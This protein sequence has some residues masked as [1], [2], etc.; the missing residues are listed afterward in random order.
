MRTLWL[1]IVG[2]MAVVLI[3]ALGAVGYAYNRAATAGLGVYV[4]TGGLRWAQ[5]LA[6]QLEDYYARVGSWDGVAA[7]L[8][9]YPTPGAGRG[10]G[11]MAGAGGGLPPGQR[12][13]VADA[14]GRVVADTFGELIGQTLAEDD[15]QQGAPL[16]VNGA[17]V[18]TLVVAA[19]MLNQGPEAEFLTTV[20]NGIVLGG[21]LAGVLA[22][23]LGSLLAFQVTSPL[24]ALTRA[25]RR[26]AGGDLAQRIPVRSRD[27]VG[28]LTQAFNEMAAAL[29]RNEQARRNMIADIAH[30]LRTPLTAIRGN[31]EGILDGVFPASG[32][33]V[34]P[35]YEQTLLLSRL[36]DDLRDLAL[37]D[38][39]QLRL[40]RRPLDVAELLQG[41][42]AA[43]QP[44]A[45]A[46]GIHLEVRV[47]EALP[48]VHA[49]P[50]RMR[51]VL[52]NLVGNALRH[53]PEGGAITLA[54]EAAEGAITVSVRDTG[55]GIDPADLPRIFD[56][57]YRGDPSRA[58][59]SGGHGL[60]LAIVKRWV[61]LHGGRV[62]AENLPSGGAQFSFTL[63]V[64]SGESL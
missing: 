20:R 41:V 49:D 19:P 36:V 54:A 46:Q 3:L 27:E 60:G 40:E 32:E 50:M 5:A 55:P 30:E 63:P 14:Q 37:A 11:A 56:R 16:S 13:I 4:S 29:E 24:R 34:A 18:G 8:G 47:A 6:P 9:A 2:V 21:V 1:K 25:A 53:T 48:P 15:L 23:L 12:V 38:A 57:F 10:H 58:R 35:V 7:F 64:V 44:Q 39:G 59:D 61:E 17:R 33:S 62:W 45:A 26:V 42:A 31:L 43:V 52:L 22:L 51:Q 28:E